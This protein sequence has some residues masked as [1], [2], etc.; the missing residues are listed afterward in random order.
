MV[1]YT[2]LHQYD[3]EQE[4]GRDRDREEEEE[5]EEE[6]E[7]DEEALSLC[8]FPLQG[9]NKESTN[10]A[11]QNSARPSSE[12]AEFF[13]FFSD[14]GSDQMS[15]AEDIIFHGKLVPFIDPYFTPQN[16][17]K[18]DK[19]RI[20]FR[21]RCESLSELQSS[22]SRS[23]ST[24]NGIALMRNSRSLDYRNLE[25]F[26]SSKRFSPELDIERSSSL[27]SIHAKGEVK[28]TTSKPR[29]YLLMF[30]VVRPPTE[31]DLSDIKSR[32]VRRNSSMT[33]FPHV[34][35]DGK[36]APVSQSSISKGSCKLLRV[37]SCKDPA[38]VAVATSF[39]SP[40]V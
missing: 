12:P 40:Q 1:D 25:R 32:Q 36:K 6:E 27:K 22:V 24:K 19:Q 37:L 29:W 20:S 35:T 13:E 14:L 9:R 17:T 30:G 3:R 15:S 26:S 11:T 28:R 5:K 7:E 18:E 33:M 16:Q 21:R 8:D 39:L 23:N 4:H 10:I 38:S 2:N 34:D 31:M